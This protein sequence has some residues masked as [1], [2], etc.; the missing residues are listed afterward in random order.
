M[1]NTQPGKPVGQPMGGTRE[2]KKKNFDKRFF[3]FAGLALLLGLFVWTVSNSDNTSHLSNLDPSD[4]PAN[5]IKEQI[6]DPA[7]ENL[8]TI[9]ASLSEVTEES[10]STSKTNSSSIAVSKSGAAASKSETAG[11]KSTSSASN[12]GKKSQKRKASKNHS[13]KNKRSNI[14]YTIDEEALEYY[15]SLEAGKQAAAFQKSH[16][17]Q[18]IITT[19]KNG[20][21]EVRFKGDPSISASMYQ[22]DSDD[23]TEDFTSKGQ[24]SRHGKNEKLYDASEF[25]STIIDGKEYDLN[26][27]FE[28]VLFDNDGTIIPHS[29]VSYGDE[30]YPLR[31]T[32]PWHPYISLAYIKE[33]KEVFVAEKVRKM[34]TYDKSNPLQTP[35]SMGDRHG[36]IDYGV[37]INPK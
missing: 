23:D 15:S 9:G 3:I 7:A 16:K 8:P 18:D 13:G 21:L 36:K 34:P 10:G 12:S 27:L 29:G 33:E 5:S 37:T 14:R 31:D 28:D 4:N 32:L 35:G 20:K 24:A 1:K 22:L 6:K 11:K 17:G 26:D 25:Y 2:R 30:F 19:I